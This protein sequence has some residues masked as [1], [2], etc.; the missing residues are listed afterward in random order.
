M[1]IVD[2]AAGDQVVG[3]AG[4]CT[5]QLAPLTSQ[6]L[7]H[8]SCTHLLVLQPLLVLALTPARHFLALLEAFRLGEDRLRLCRSV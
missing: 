4:R 2:W 7:S 5:L 8:D 3:R 1:G 6:S